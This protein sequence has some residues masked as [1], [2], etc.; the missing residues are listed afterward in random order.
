MEIA[1]VGGDGTFGGFITDELRR[2]GHDVRVLSRNG[3]LT[4]PDVRGKLSFA[5]WLGE[6]RRQARPAT[7]LAAAA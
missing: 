3:A 5:G 7:P 6:Q 4:A 2:R 1:V